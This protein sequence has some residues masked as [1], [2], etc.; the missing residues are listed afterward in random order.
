MKISYVA[1]DTVWKILNI[2]LFEGGQ[3]ERDL[4][5]VPRRFRGGRGRM[6]MAV[7]RDKL[8]ACSRNCVSKHVPLPGL[9]V[10]TLSSSL[11]W[12]ESLLVGFAD[13]APGVVTRILAGI[14]GTPTAHFRRTQAVALGAYRMRRL[15]SKG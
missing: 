2:L 11:L 13:H 5:V 12:G 10:S 1:L 9:T 15:S 8:L 14:F 7:G 4:V 6:P 3:K